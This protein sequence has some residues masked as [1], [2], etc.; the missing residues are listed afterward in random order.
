[1]RHKA[2]QD[3]DGQAQFFKIS[4]RLALVQTRKQGEQIPIHYNACAE[5]R[6]G[7]YGKYLCSKRVDASG[8]C[9][10]CG[11][12]GKTA[13]R[14]NVRCRFTDVGDSAWLTTFHDAA[15][16]VI[17]MTADQVATLERDQLDAK[18][19]QHYFTEPLE[20]TVR[21][22]LDTYQGETRP[23]VTCTG[24]APVNRREHGRRLLAEINELIQ[25]GVTARP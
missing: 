25:K 13:V 20:L 9:A 16:K 2:Q 15:E 6:E 19:R 3:A 7:Q 24:A 11:L 5:L 14:L 1:M 8:Y 18:L 22:K 10:A 17:G 4:A 21:A 12:A 23:N